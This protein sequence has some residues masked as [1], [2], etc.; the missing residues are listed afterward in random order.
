MANPKH[1]SFSQSEVRNDFYFN[2]D[3]TNLIWKTGPRKG[4]IAGWVDSNGYQIIRYKGILVRS[5]NLIWLM[6]KSVWPSKELDHKDNNP[7]NN[8]INNLRESDRKEQ[9]ANQKLQSRRVGKFK[10]VHK[11]S[12]G[13]WCVKIKHHSKQHYFG[14]YASELEAAMIYNINAEKLFG[15]FAHPNK[16]F[17]DVQ[18]ND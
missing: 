4:K 14:S 13:N 9:G 3:Y 17:E 12:S 15:E 8:S 2:E 11:T 7:Q 5:H 10:G 18:V 16:V 1:R 6:Y